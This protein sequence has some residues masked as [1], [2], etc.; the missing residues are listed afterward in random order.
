MKYYMER[1][2][3]GCVGNCLLFWKEG[4]NGYT[5]DI[6]E[7]KVWDSEDP[8]F[9]S[10]MTGSKKYRAWP[11]EHINARIVHHVDHQTLDL[12]EGKTGDS[13]GEGK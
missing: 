5:C 1:A 6:K 3:S 9:I 7:A 10:A 11:V 8:R 12:D 4:N 13:F 2:A